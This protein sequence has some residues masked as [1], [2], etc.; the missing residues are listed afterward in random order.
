MGDQIKG[1]QR[2]FEGS[3][4]AATTI[5]SMR[6]WVFILAIQLAG[7]AVLIHA[8]DQSLRQADPRWVYLAVLTALGSAVSVKLS[9]SE[10]RSGSVAI[11][12]GDFF[13]FTA[14][15]LV[16]PAAGALMGALEGLVSSWRLKVR[17]WHKLFFNVFQLVL[18]AYLVGLCYQFLRPLGSDEGKSG[19][20]ALL[21]LVL[22]CALLYFLLNS[23]ILGLAMALASRRS[24]PAV[25]RRGFL[26]SLP[27]N[28]VNAC[29]VAIAM[30]LMNPL[31]LWLAAA[32]VPLIIVAYVLRGVHQT[33]KRKAEGR[34]FL[35]VPF[36]E[37]ALPVRARGYL[38]VVLAVAL[39]IFL[40]SLHFSCTSVDLNWLY[41]AVLAAAASLFP[42][43]LLSVR[44]KIWLTLGDVFV[45][46]AFFKFG[47]EAATVIAAVEALA[48]NLRRRPRGVYRWTFNTAQLVVTAFA[49]GHLFR[50]LEEMSGLMHPGQVGVL[51][52]LVALLA[53]MICGFFYYL[54]TLSLTAEAMVLA[55]GGSFRQ[56]WQQNVGW[57]YP[58]VLGALGGASAYLLIRSVSLGL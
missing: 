56:L 12:A 46:V 57:C 11:S 2:R 32:L 13:I 27:A 50:F 48:F 54:V 8:I 26:W 9:G 23:T 49:V 16:G 55:R 40:Y 53:P 25:F 17:H 58:S 30:A 38:Y 29:L 51:H 34:G 33:D 1:Q 21:V 14:I 19:L 41:L 18:S 28:C 10:K 15:V 47:P 6:T 5:L 22:F 7:L 42:L 39:P 24:I 37:A 36:F 20:G 43:R 4:Q 3:S 45:F 52:L 35:S 31:N 44:D